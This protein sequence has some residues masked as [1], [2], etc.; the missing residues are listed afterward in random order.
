MSA[1]P[2]TRQPVQPINAL[3]GALWAAKRGLR[4]LRVAPGGK[5][6]YRNGVNEATT[7][8]ATIERWF[9]EEP[10][11][12]YGIAMGGPDRLVALDCDTKHASYQV[13]YLSL[14]YQTTLEFESCNG[15]AH[16][17]FSVDFDAGQKDLADATSINVRAEGGYIVGPGSTVDGKRYRIRRRCADRQGSGRLGRAHKPSRRESARQLDADRRTRHAQRHGSSS[18][19]CRRASRRRRRRPR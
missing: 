13:D 12:N 9:A 14:P 8:A 7:D 18:S 11:L 1:A 4:V 5:V 15:G 2:A 19:H 16:I 10:R 3:A 6:P 17:V